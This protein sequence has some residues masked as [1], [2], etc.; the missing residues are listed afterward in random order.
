MATHTSD[1]DKDRKED[2]GSDNEDE[3]IFHDARFPAEE[4]TVSQQ[5][6]PTRGRTS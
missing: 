2:D 3:D 5:R 1:K 4:E 6:F